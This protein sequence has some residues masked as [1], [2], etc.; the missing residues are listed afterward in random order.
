VIQKTQRGGRFEQLATRQSHA[1]AGVFGVVIHDFPENFPEDQ[2]SLEPTTGKNP[3][4]DVGVTHPN[5]PGEPVAA[6]SPVVSGCCGNALTQLGISR[7]IGVR[8]SQ[9]GWHQGF[10]FF[11]AAGVVL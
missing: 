7:L 4:A 10:G 9:G 5:Q 2:L 6:T 8:L 3:V 1:V 11:Y